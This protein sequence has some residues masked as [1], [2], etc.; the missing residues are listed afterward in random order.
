MDEFIEDNPF[1]YKSHHI[2]E[3]YEFL[4]AV[5]FGNSDYANEALIKNDIF[6]CYRLL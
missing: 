6:F 5:K 2:T 4:Q 3:S 1:L